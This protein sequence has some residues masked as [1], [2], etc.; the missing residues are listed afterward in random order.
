MSCEKIRPQ[1][2][3]LA[4]NMWLRLSKTMLTVKNF[5]PNKSY[6][7]EVTSY[8]EKNALTKLGEGI[9]PGMRNNSFT[10]NNVLITY[11]II[12]FASIMIV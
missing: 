8:G 12:T 9:I 11:A 1:D 7:M 10:L 5:C 4:K 2:N 6:L 3:Y